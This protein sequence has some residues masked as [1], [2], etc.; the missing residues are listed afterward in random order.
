MGFLSKLFGGGGT[1]ERSATVVGK[2]A[3]RMMNA[4][5]LLQQAAATGRLEQSWQTW[6]TTPDALI[7]QNWRVLVA[8]SREQYEN[9]D[10]ARKFIQMVRE[11]VVGPCGF[12][13]QAGI[14]DPNG[15]TDILASKAIEEAFD[16]FSRKGTFEITGTMSRAEVE[17]L[18]VSTVAIDG[19]VFAVKVRG[20]EAPNGAF[21]VQLMDPML[22]HP[23]HFEPLGNGNS[24]RHGIEFTPAG[25]PVA[26]Y[27]QQYDERQVG[28]VQMTW[29]SAMRIPAED[30]IHL[31]VPEKIGQKRGLPWMR[32]ALWRMR[33]LSGFEDAAVTNAR[34]GAAKMGFFRDPNMDSEPG[35]EPFQM[36]AEPGVFEDIGSKEFVQFNPQFPSD[37]FDPFV[38]AM[39][40]S[41]ASGLGVSYN[42]IANDLTSVNFSSIRQGALDEREVWK[43]LQEWFISSWCW[44]VYEAWLQMGLLSNSITVAGKPLK[45]ER[46]EKYKAVSWQGRR[47]SWIDPASEMS[48]NQIA[49]GLNLTSP[50]AIIRDSGRDPED[51]FEEIARDKKEKARLGIEDVPLPGSPQAQQ[52]Q[53]KQ[54][55]KPSNE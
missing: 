36:D 41:I 25:R 19:E 5:G 10:H 17:R 26:Y 15:T 45:F 55:P 42:N 8:R 54:K 14:K 34:I 23:Q 37:N 43:G 40:R 35:D 38:K 47:W 6:P 49:L 50:S 52:Q 22:V 28:Y 18:I 20:S 30:V 13:L 12:E 21:C 2:R 4:A 51:V 44:P 9:N 16:A 33:M 1:E 48:A 39:L 53:Q 24:I 29:K 7:Y 46:L 27:F 11:N 3:G 32:T 31:F